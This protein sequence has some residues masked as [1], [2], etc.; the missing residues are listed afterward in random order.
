MTAHIT[1]VVPT[2]NRPRLLAEA[3][4]S[5]GQQTFADWE[6]IVVDDASTPA[7]ESNLG[8]PRIRVVGVEPGRGGAAAKNRGIAEA[9]GEIIA[10]LDDYDEYDPAYLARALDAHRAPS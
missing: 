2:Q 6:A 7:V 8:D 10:Y 5:L 3:L 9:H 1:V 4:A